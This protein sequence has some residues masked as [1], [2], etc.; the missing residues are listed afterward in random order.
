MKTGL[1]TIFLI[2]MLNHAAFPKDRIQHAQEDCGYFMCGFEKENID[3]IIL[4][5]AAE[6]RIVMFGEI[7]DSVIAGSPPPLEDS[8][9]VI[10]LLQRLKTIG[11]SY[12]ALEV[13]KNAPLATHS[14]D[15]VRCLADY[16]RGEQIH[17]EDYLYAK[18]GWV[19]LMVQALQ[20]G[21]KPVFFTIQNIGA[22]RDEEMFLSIKRQIFD[23]DAEA[24]VLVYVGADHISKM[25]TCWR[26]AGR[27]IVRRPLGLLLNDLTHGRNYSV[28]AGYPDDTPAGC[29]LIISRFVWTNFRNSEQHIHQTP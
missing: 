25:E 26:H 4:A 15:M 16:R 29:D 27:S 21:F 19:Q 14:H 10:S 5:N 22:D 13:Q 1:M 28:Y 3:T 6:N 24:R 18:P 20:N 8:L 11:Y 9:Y 17:A 12:M 2:M 23:L 7:H